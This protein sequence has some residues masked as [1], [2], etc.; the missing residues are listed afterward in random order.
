METTEQKELDLTY[1]D[2]YMNNRKIIEKSEFI[3]FHFLTHIDVCDLKEELE[4]WLNELIERKKNLKCTS[5]EIIC[6]DSEDEYGNYKEEY[7]IVYKYWE[8]KEEFESRLIQTETKFEEEFE[9]NLKLVMSMP[10][11]LK[12]KFVAEL[13]ERDDDFSM[14]IK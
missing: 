2:N 3:D 5:M 9:N 8:T 6:D 14:Y 7:Y 12:N 13:F 4:K 10:K 11:T 1:N